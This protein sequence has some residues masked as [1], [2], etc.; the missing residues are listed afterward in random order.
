MRASRAQPWWAAFDDP[1]LDALV[2]EALENSPD[3]EAARTRV[4]Q[5]DAL[6]NQA[7]AGVLPQLTADVSANLLP[8]NTRGFQFGG[9]PSLPGAPEPPPVYMTA[10]A[11]VNGAVPLDFWGEALQTRRAQVFNAV[12][13]RGDREALALALSGRV[14]EA[15]LDIH[16]ARARVAIV[17][18]QLAATEQ[19]LELVELRYERG[20]SSGL[21][22][23][24]QR[25][26]VAGTAAQLP[27]ARS[28]LRVREEQLRTLLGRPAGSPLTL[29]ERDL[30]DLPNLAG[31]VDAD[32]VA[33]G[34]PDLRAAAARVDA[35]RFQRRS[36]L[37]AFLPNLRMTGQVGWQFFYEEELLTQF[38]WGVGLN[39]SVP[40]F[41]GGANHA[42]LRAAR[43][44]EAGARAAL[45]QST[46]QAGLEIASAQASEEEQRLVLVAQQDQRDAAAL[47]FDESVAS[48]R[49]GFASYLQV[50]T[51]LTTRGQ[52]ELSL[53]QARRDLL[54]ARLQLEQA[55]GGPWTRDLAGDDR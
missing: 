12:A 30:P 3:L 4:E 11:V 37:H 25:Q 36:A 52:S 46:L 50:L 28:L 44:G 8:T 53:V 45:E 18:E 47:A 20:D 23:L 17:S 35:A 39:L 7:L 16:T 51:A 22:V 21:D 5:A 43:A 34:R 19:L 13:S 38:G 6:A 1:D 41:M 48:Y 10:S 9:I 14:I 33:E 15:W 49:G 2:E 31:E 27:Q 42:G 24:Q 32:E 54:G 40:I 26:Q 55:R 29:A